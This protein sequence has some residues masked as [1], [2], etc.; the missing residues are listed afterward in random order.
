MNQELIYQSLIL[1]ASGIAPSGVSVVEGESYGVRFDPPIGRNPSIAVDI[2]DITEA[3][4]ELGSFGSFYFA[5]FHITAQSRKQRD[6]LK[7]VVYSGCIHREIPVYSSFTPTGTV[8]SG[9]TIIAYA[10]MQ[11][12]SSRDVLDFQSNRERLFWAATVFCGVTVLG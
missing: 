7:S 4:I 8:A 9:A 10:D 2:G 6:A 11:N 12:I 1:F 5:T 3:N